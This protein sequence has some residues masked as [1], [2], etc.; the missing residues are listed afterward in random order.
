MVPGVGRFDFGD[1]AKNQ[2]DSATGP[3]FFLF[4]QQ[5]LSGGLVEDAV[6]VKDVG[7]HISEGYSAIPGD[8]PA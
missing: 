2:L 3:W 1:A 8:W 4:F 6:F 7:D 5:P